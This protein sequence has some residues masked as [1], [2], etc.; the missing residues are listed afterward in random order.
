MK[1]FPK[2]K[3]IAQFCADKFTIPTYY[4]LRRKGWGPEEFRVP[5]LRGAIITDEAETAWLKRMSD[6]ATKRKTEQE[7]RRRSHQSRQAGRIA[8]QIRHGS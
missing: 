3:T 7:F 5:G 6:R 1:K 4:S 2:G 8:A